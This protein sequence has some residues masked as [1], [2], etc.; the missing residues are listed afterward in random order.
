MAVGVYE[1]KCSDAKCS[2]IPNMR[3]K[4]ALEKANGEIKNCLFISVCTVFEEIV[5]KLCFYKQCYIFIFPKKRQINR[6]IFDHFEILEL[7]N[8]CAYL[9]NTTASS[10]DNGNFLFSNVANVEKIYIAF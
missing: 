8:N 5:A 6:V 1:R 7:I 2:E 4:R 10:R 3:D 9:N